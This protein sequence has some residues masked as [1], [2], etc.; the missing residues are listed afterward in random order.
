MTDL[1]KLLKLGLSEVAQCV[2]VT[3][4]DLAQAH[5]ADAVTHLSH[6]QKSGSQRLSIQDN[7]VDKVLKTMIKTFLFLLWNCVY[8]IFHTSNICKD[9][10]ES[11]KIYWRFHKNRCTLV[12][13]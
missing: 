10:F 11:Y 5:V 7:N 9:P 4:L 13:N 2:R 3:F 1:I 8:K 12:K 6:I